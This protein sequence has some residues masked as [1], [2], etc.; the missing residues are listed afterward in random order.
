MGGVEPAGRDGADVAATGEGGIEPAGRGGADAAAT[1]E[2]GVAAAVNTGAAEAA[3]GA[4]GFPAAGGRGSSTYIVA[5]VAD[6]RDKGP[7]TVADGPLAGGAAG[8]AGAGFDG[9]AA[10]GPGGRAACAGAPPPVVTGDVS[11]MVL[12]TPGTGR[13]RKSGAGVSAVGS[14][15]GPPA[16]CDPPE[17][18]VRV[19]STKKSMA[20][21]VISANGLAA[22]AGSDPGLGVWGVTSTG[23]GVWATGPGV[24]LWGP[25]VLASTPGVGNSAGRPNRVRVRLVGRGP[26]ASSR[27]RRSNCWCTATLASSSRR[28]RN[29][30]PALPMTPVPS[31]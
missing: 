26:A 19:A 7:A 2:G 24:R 20:F 15:P 11:T 14:P 29:S 10:T 5:A 8:A 18:S 27:F 31:R 12:R 25:G 23:A 6:T 21:V 9:A 30:T 17:S 22:G 28:T 4:A 13:P 3:G 1:G 16:K